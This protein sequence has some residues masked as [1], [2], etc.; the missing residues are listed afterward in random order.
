MAQFYNKRDKFWIR[1]NLYNFKG[2]LIDTMTFAGQKV[3]HYKLDGKMNFENEIS[4]FSYHEY[5]VDSTNFDNYYATEL[6][7]DYTITKDGFF[8][9]N[10]L[11]KERS[12]FTNFGENNVVSRVDTI[13]K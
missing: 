13:P 2:N 10:K 12:Y 8:K 4:T 3:G 9:L 1:L 7:K 11:C 6:R 5:K